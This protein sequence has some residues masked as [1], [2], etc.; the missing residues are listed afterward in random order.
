[1]PHPWIPNSDPKI[2]QYM[3]KRIGVSSFEELI[4][5]IPERI[6]LKHSLNIGYDRYLS[7][8]EVMKFFDERLSKNRYYRSPPPFIGGTYCIHYVPSVIKHILMRSEFYT[9]YTPYHAE[10]QQGILQALFEYQSLIAE[11]Y[12][13]EIVNASMYDGS[14]A[15]AEAMRMAARVTRKKKIAVPRTM[16]KE[17]LEV[18]KTWSYGADLEIIEINYCRDKGFMDL[19]DLKKK[20]SSKDFAAVIVENPSYLGFIEE[21]VEDISEIAHDYGALYIVYADP[22]SLAILKPPGDYGAD[23][24]VGDG[25][26]LG[27]GLNYGGPTLGIL[28]T[29]KDPRLVRQMPGRIVG[30]TTTIDGNE[31]GYALIWQ[32]REQHIRRERATSNITTNSALM[33]IAAA[34]YISLLGAK[35]LRKLAESIIARVNYAIKRLS[36]IKEIKIPALNAKFFKN[37]PIKFNGIRYLEIHKKLL[38]RGIIG[39]KYLGKEFPELGESCLMCFTEVHSK[40]DIDTLVKALEEVIKN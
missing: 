38:K 9:A 29:R 27:L 7:E 25:Q 18:L 39:G 22:L 20:L 12:G 15:L 23:I 34:I 36:I 30:M 24:V 40:K 32:T 37:V 33:A 31:R 4:S 13:V 14:T 28:G 35:G 17:H 26:P 19:E 6:R 3:L 1:M 5:G 21:N 10:I 2:K 8:F 11:L 16:D